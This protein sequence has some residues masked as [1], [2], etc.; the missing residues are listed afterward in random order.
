MIAGGLELRRFLKTVSWTALVSWEWSGC[1]CDTRTYAARRGSFERSERMPR[2]RAFLGS[3][4]VKFE[5]VSDATMVARTVSAVGVADESPTMTASRT[6]IGHS[7]S[8]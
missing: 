2:A 7:W 8:L 6:D 3:V 1:V 4:K 5:K